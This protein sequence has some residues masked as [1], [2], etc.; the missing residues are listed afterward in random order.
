LRNNRRVELVL[1]QQ[2]AGR[3]EAVTHNRLPG[4]VDLPEAEWQTRWTQN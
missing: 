4:P 1:P 2:F 3:R